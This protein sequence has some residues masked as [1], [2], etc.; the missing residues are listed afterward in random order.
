[1]KQE[2]N[3]LVSALDGYLKCISRLCAN[4]YAFASSCYKANHDI[5]TFCRNF[6][7]L[8]NAVDNYTNHQSMNI[9][10]IEK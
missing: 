2:S 6:A 4:N 1:M 3:T 5:D 10:V 7:S 9:L 8:I